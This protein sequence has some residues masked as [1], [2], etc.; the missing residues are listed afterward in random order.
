MLHEL[1]KNFFAG[2][3]EQ[4]RTILDSI[5]P[6]SI[7]TPEQRLQVYRNNAYLILTEH[8]QKIFPVTTKLVGNSF[9]RQSA[10]TFITAQ[11]PTSGDMTFY[12]EN[13]PNFLKYLPSLS[14]HPYTGD[15]AMLE[16][17]YYAAGVLPLRP[18]IS[19]EQFQQ[20][21]QSN[22]QI[23]EMAFQPHVS[24]LK[25]PYPVLDIWQH[26]RN[27]KEDALDK[28]EINQPC[29]LI[30]Y[31]NGH[32]VML[33][34]VDEAVFAFSDTIKT[35]ETAEKSVDAALRIDPDFQPAEHIQYFLCNKMLCFPEKENRETP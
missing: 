11:P 15:V 32:E 24:I 26:I 35:G 1:Q 10:K 6:E 20:E 33:L 31:R 12:G 2:I 16:W 18:V 27:D 28:L 19:P 13:F 8:L 34:S 5:Q 9:F 29:Y 25:S 23:I 7:I 30:I 14:A 22:G 3:F 17:H 4:D 21:L